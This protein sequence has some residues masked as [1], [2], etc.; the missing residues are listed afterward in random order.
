M[1]SKGEVYPLVLIKILTFLVL[2]SLIIPLNCSYSLIWEINLLP[3][4]DFAVEGSLRSGTGS[5]T[6]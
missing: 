4:V 6:H 3:L 2:E 1:S 5:V